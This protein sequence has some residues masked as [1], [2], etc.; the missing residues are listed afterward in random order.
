MNEKSLEVS[1]DLNDFLLGK[2]WT[3]EQILDLIAPS[4]EEIVPVISWLKAHG[5]SQ[6]DISGRDFVKVVATVGTIQELFQTKMY[7]FLS[8]H[9]GTNN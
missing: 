1:N 7:N 5:V 9:N 2:W 8:E 3:S 6:I 4:N